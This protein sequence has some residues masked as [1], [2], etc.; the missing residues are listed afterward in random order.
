MKHPNKKACEMSV[1]ELAKTNFVS[2]SSI[3]FHLNILK[4]AKLVNIVAINTN[5]GKKRIANRSCFNINIDML[6]ENG[7]I[8][9]NDKYYE[10]M[11]VGCFTDAEFGNKSGFIGKDRIIALY[12]DGPFIPERFEARALY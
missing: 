12:G 6:V 8:F 7:P 3:M 1:A 5:H 10:S 2:I 4:E 9:S 11:P